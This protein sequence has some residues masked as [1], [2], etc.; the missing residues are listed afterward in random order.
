MTATRTEG[1]SAYDAASDNA[2]KNDLW[3]AF[4]AS[5]P[6]GKGMVWPTKRDNGACP[7][8]DEEVKDIAARAFAKL[9]HLTPTE[10]T[11]LVDASLENP[12][13]ELWVYIRAVL[14]RLGLADVLTDSPPNQTRDDLPHQP[15]LHLLA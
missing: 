7:A 11:D 15:R 13:L 2:A 5:M 12:D 10:K 1:S 6:Q 4:D 8:T 3:G 9:R 14:E